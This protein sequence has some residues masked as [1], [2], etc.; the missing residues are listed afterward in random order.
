[1]CDLPSSSETSSKPPSQQK[2]GSRIRIKLKR[3]KHRYSSEKQE[4]RESSEPPKAKRALFS[5]GE[6]NGSVTS[7]HSS[8]TSSLRASDSATVNGFEAESPA[9]PLTLNNASTNSLLSSD[10]RLPRISRK[11]SLAQV[12]QE[13]LSTEEDEADDIEGEQYFCVGLSEGASLMLYL[14]TVAG[15]ILGSPLRSVEAVTREN[16][17]EMGL[18]QASKFGFMIETCILAA[19]NDEGLVCPAHKDHPLTIRDIAPDLVCLSTVC[20]YGTVNVR[21]DQNRSL[22]DRYLPTCHLNTSL[23]LVVLTKASTWLRGLL[24][25]S[26]VEQSILLQLPL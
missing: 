17:S 2:R 22:F 12:F 8:S 10:E 7:S 23:I 25:R 26:T 5:V 9:S 15:R 19:R 4:R 21:A 18:T 14:S 16:M 11:E 1:M 6:T 13:K 3:N 20:M 24:V